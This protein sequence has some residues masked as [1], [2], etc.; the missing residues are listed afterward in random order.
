MAALGMDGQESNAMLGGG[1]HGP[2]DGVRDVVELQVQHDVE[3]E[4]LPQGKD[5]GPGCHEELEAHFHH[6]NM[7]VE[8]RSQV[9]SVRHVRD[10][11][12]EDDS[13]MRSD[14]HSNVLC[15]GLLSQFINFLPKS[16]NDRPVMETRDT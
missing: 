11:Q 16:H 14:V 9:D 10:V 15:R 5:A 13:A 2:G 7:L 4:L 8:I 1:L 3:A 12:G 6:P